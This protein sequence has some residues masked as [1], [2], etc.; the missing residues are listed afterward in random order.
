MNRTIVK[1]VAKSKAISLLMAVLLAGGDGAL[2]TAGPKPAKPISVG[3]VALLAMPQKYNGKIIRTWGFLNLRSDDNAVFLHEED[4]RIPLLKNSFKLELTPEQETK[5]KP[6][7]LTYVMIEG[8]MRSQGP[9]GPALNSG[10]IAH[11]TLI[12]GWAPYMPFEPSKKP[13]APQ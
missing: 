5:F 3:M 10:T 13:E 1:L 6:L 4:L 11:V 9:D 2:S 12:H 7:N 8:T